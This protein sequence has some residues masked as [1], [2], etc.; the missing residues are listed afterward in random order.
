MKVLTQHLTEK[1]CGLD[2]FIKKSDVI[3][4]NLHQMG[5][6]LGIDCCYNSIKL[7]TSALSLATSA[8]PKIRETIGGYSLKFGPPLWEHGNTRKL[9]FSVFQ[10][11][12]PEWR[13]KY[14]S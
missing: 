12:S 13:V 6:A 11:N 14:L 9:T 3:D 5:D 7:I 4:A 10:K 2:N 1:N 8:L